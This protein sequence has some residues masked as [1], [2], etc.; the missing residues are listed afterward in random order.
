MRYDFGSDNTAGMAPSAIDGLVRA[1]EAFARAYG[2]D[3]ITTRAADAI[4]ARL[5]ADAEVRFVFSGTAANAI[6]L[7]MLAWPYEAVLA[8]ARAQQARDFE[9]L[10][11]DVKAL[12]RGLAEQF[13][14]P[15]ERVFE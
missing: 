6:A 13:A 1:N 9:A 12:S 4:R 5:D 15:D 11:E 7:S 14:L 8:S 3:E 2:A 10:P